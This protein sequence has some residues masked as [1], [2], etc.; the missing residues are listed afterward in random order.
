MGDAEALNRILVTGEL[1]IGWI[2]CLIWGLESQLQGDVQ[3]FKKV[4]S[5][6]PTAC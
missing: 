2:L 4:N 1:P 5:R 3:I 6:S